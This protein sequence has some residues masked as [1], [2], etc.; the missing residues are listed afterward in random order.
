MISLKEVLDYNRELLEYTTENWMYEISSETYVLNE[1]VDIGDF[2]ID[3]CTDITLRVYLPDHVLIYNPLWT[4]IEEVFIPC[5][6][7]SI[8]DL[9]FTDDIRNF[10]N[11]K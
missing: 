8:N 2:Y 3:S 9:V 5:T 1:N 11:K 6:F 4:Y 10:T 7:T